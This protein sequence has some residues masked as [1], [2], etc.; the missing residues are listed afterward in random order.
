MRHSINV[1]SMTYATDLASHKIYIQHLLG[2]KQNMATGLLTSQCLLLILNE[3]KTFIAT[4]PRTRG[5]FRYVVY[6]ALCF[7]LEVTETLLGL[8]HEK[9]RFHWLGL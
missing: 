2:N 3:A 8:Y 7:K 6:N 1:K 5:Y 9:I 4:V